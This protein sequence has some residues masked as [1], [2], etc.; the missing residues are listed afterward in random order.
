MSG[1]V[2]GANE[3]ELGS[4]ERKGRIDALSGSVEGANEKAEREHHTKTSNGDAGYP[5]GGFGLL[6][7]TKVVKE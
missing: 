6:L 3:R 5:S 2:E 1:S 4:I 7:K